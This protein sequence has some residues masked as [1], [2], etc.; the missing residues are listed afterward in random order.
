M[1]EKE[2]DTR[3]QEAV[4]IVKMTQ[5]SFTRCTATSLCLLQTGYFWHFRTH[6]H[7]RIIWMLLKLMLGCKSV[8][9][10]LMK[11]YIEIINSIVKK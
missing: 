10:P 3:F 2:L 11:Q 1:N 4:D 6:K 7:Q 8:I 5:A 9:Y